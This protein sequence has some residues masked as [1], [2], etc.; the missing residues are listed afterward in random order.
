MNKKVA[1]DEAPKI[2]SRRKLIRFT[3]ASMT[4]SAAGLFLNAC[5][6]YTEPR[7]LTAIENEYLEFPIPRQIVVSI[8]P[9]KSVREALGDETRI[10]W[11]RDDKRAKYITLAYAAQELQQHLALV[12]VEVSISV[13]NELTIPKQSSIILTVAE[14]ENKNTVSMSDVNGKSN[15]FEDE[16]FEIVPKNNH[17]Y[18]TA[19]NRIGVL[20]GVYRLLEHIGFAWFD[21]YETHVP[22]SKVSMVDLKWQR[23][24]EA[25]KIQ[26]RGFWIYDTIPDEFAI[27]LRRNRFNIGGLA[28]SHVKHKLGLKGWGGEH[29]LLQQEFSPAGLFEKHPEWYSL[30]SDVRRPIV[31]AG[32]Y[33]NPSF[34]N[35]EACNYFANRIIDRLENGDLKDVDILNVWPSD[36]RFNNFDQSQLAKILGNETD[37]LLHFNAVVADQLKRAYSEGRLSR[38]VIMAGNSYYLTMMPPTNQKIIARLENARYLHIFYPIDRSWSGEIDSDLENRRANNKFVQ[39]LAKWKEAAKFSYGVVDY[40]NFSVFAA[41]GLNDMQFFDHN[42]KVL[43]SARDGLFAYMHPML[44]NPGPRRLTNYLMSQLSWFDPKSDSGDKLVKNKSNQITVNFFDKRYGK[45]SSPWREIHELMARSAENAQ[46]IFGHNSLYWVLF[47]HFM[48]N[49]AFYTPEECIKFIG[50]YLIGGTQELPARFSMDETVVETFIGL[51]ESLKLQETARLKWVKTLA[52]VSDSNVQKRMESDVEWFKATA[53]RYH[54]MKLT[55]DYFIASNKK[56]DVNQLSAQIQHE[57]NFLKQSQV[58]KDTISPV[59]QRVFLDHHQRMI[60]L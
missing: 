29:N 15:F 41:V 13:S 47:Q 46:E 27:W 28:R 48:W 6:F 2:N 56:R 22:V 52:N 5:D 59:N 1:A 9:Y 40:H 23:I 57:I 60:S 43:T 39:N 53:S 45:W 8:G 49:P 10:D 20:N 33:F 11:Q 4:A 44:K 26:L 30:V 36:N 19:S 24:S 3:L 32:D 21:P 34:A 7:K 37:N 58:T 12:G 17:I 38:P 54:L 14:K 31:A 50:K 25:P 51:N 42:F 16:S 55:S 35:I 18:V